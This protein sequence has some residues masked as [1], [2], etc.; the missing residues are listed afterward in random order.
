M[1]VRGVCGSTY[2]YDEEV[3][4]LSCQ[5]IRLVARY[6]TLRAHIT[7]TC[8]VCRACILAIESVRAA[9]VRAVARDTA[10]GPSESAEAPVRLPTIKPARKRRMAGSPT[11][12]CDEISSQVIA[13]TW[14]CVWDE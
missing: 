4:A 11:I 13:S 10:D 14:P 2:E 9:E 5:T 12:S 3:N 8:T 6:L 7:N 1:I